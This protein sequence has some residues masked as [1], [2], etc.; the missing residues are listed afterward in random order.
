MGRVIGLVACLLLLGIVTETSA[1]VASIN[2]VHSIIDE[3]TGFVGLELLA[4]D[5]R[6]LAC[7]GLHKFRSDLTPDSTPEYQ[8][9][10]TYLILFKGGDPSPI[11][12]GGKGVAETK[13][14][15]RIACELK[16]SAKVSGRTIKVDYKVDYKVGKDD[17]QKSNEMLKVGGHSPK[18]GAKVFLVDLSRPDSAIQTVK[19]LPETVPDV[20]NKDNRIKELQAVID[21]LKANS[22]SVR[23]FFDERDDQP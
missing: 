9:E 5:G 17:N 16:L 15:G 2:S 11:S 1:Q 7:Y 13:S 10:F 12:V 22:A 21:E 4:I 3:K 20:L 8:S 18:D 14:G 19:V 23:E 6:P